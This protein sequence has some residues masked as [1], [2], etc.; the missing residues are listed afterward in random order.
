MR[1][2]PL[3]NKAHILPY[4]KKRLPRTHINI[5]SQRSK[6]K[7]PGVKGKEVTI[8]QSDAPWAVIYGRAR[9]GGVVTFA[10]D[11]VT[12]LHLVITFCCHEMD[13]ITRM[14][15]NESYVVF[16][17]TPDDR[18]SVSAVRPNGVV[19][20]VYLDKIFLAL[21]T[22]T[23][24]QIA[25]ADLVAQSATYF[26]GKW[27]TDHRQRGLAH[28]YVILKYNV[29]AFPKGLPDLMFDVQGKP[30]YDPRTDTTY[31]TNNGALVIADYLM[32]TKFG[33]GVPSSQIDM[34]QLSDAADICDE[35]VA[36]V[37]GAT[38][39]RY[40]ID[41]TFDTDE[42]KRSVLEKMA[43]AIGGQITFVGG[44][45]KIWPAVYRTPTLTLTESDLRSAVKIK[46]NVSRKDNFNAVR[47]TYVNAY[48][49]FEVTDY[50]P[51]INSF[52]QSQDNGERVWTEMN[53]PCTTS[54][55][56][57]QR[58]AKI[59]LEK[60][61]Q[62][63][64]VT[65]SFGL[66]AFNVE[67][68]DTVMLTLDRY[69]W[70]SK[71]F[72]VIEMELSLKGSN[73]APELIV[74]LQLR[75]TASGVYDWNLGQETTVDLAPNSVLPSPFEVPLPTGLTLESGTDEL[76]IRSDGTVFSRIKVSWDAF[77]DSFTNS[78][79]IVEVQYRKS[80]VSEW[81]QATP[82]SAELNY[83]HI[84]DVQDGVNYD[85]RI[86]SKNSLGVFS[87]WV[88]E[89]F[90]LVIGKTEPPS[91]VSYFAGTLESFGIRFNWTPINDLDVSHYEIRLS[92]ESL[93]WDTAT[94]IAEI[95]GDQYLLR[96]QIV[97]TYRF[98]IKAVDTT[99]NY[100]LNATALSVAIQKPSAVTIQHDV[101]GENIRLRWTQ[102]TGQFAIADYEIRYG[103]SYD[104]S[105]FIARIK[106][107]SINIK[108]TWTGI[109]RFWVTATDVAGN[110]GVP[111]FRDVQIY[112]P[113]AV[114]TLTAQVIDNN[115]LLRWSASIGGTLPVAY[116]KVLRG[117]TL[118]SAE[119]IGNTAG[120]F[121]A[122]FEILAGTYVYWVVPVDSAG[123]VGQ[124]VSIPAIV[125]QPPDFELLLD[126]ILDPDDASTLDNIRIETR[127]EAPVILPE[128]PLFGESR[129]G[130]LMGLFMP[131]TYSN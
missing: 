70:V 65:A 10:Y 11:N 83:T 31:Y 42:T 119:L 107:T 17:G 50:P 51:V 76:Y 109:R 52:Y 30:V 38:E 24:D 73:E 93:N 54:A 8:R 47:G 71:I 125:D 49:K 60:I 89:N 127:L 7:R 23:E 40:P 94:F 120:T 59:E 64:E 37:S 123:N 99:G 118:E 92:D 35:V 9:V 2:T 90:H 43:T 117:D 88:M 108:G 81:S 106:G 3:D 82:V 97:S 19:R 41:L 27:T 130:E 86:R 61:R 55:A 114:T 75:E 25:Q 4:K 15:I 56:A 78:S 20:T 45:W 103:V 80:T 85:V 28:A 104:L 18:W 63:I 122:I 26:P 21:N 66:R 69:G 44:K 72:E 98:L 58:M 126:V 13:S 57:C 77:N 53:F 62:P 129:A 124:A 36:V 128:P 22:G 46:T 112:A 84:L 6:N 5:N 105:A 95:A 102:S 34:D 87:D 121:S 67:V 29:Q 131:L 33:L 91:D 96:M 74:D 101:I 14:W 113:F 116:Y 12:A 32:D 48:N 110:D 79:G 115:V 1:K 16:G 39:I 68:P 111:A 100:S